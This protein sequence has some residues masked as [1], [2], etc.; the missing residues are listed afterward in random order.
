MNEKAGSS[1]LSIFFLITN[2]YFM[3][4]SKVYRGKPL[5]GVFFSSHILESGGDRQPWATQSMT[6]SLCY[7]E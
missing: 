5:F 1:T 6:C 3:L 4:L 2:A 7:S